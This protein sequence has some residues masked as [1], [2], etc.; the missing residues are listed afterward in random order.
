MHCIHYII[1]HFYSIGRGTD[2]L[3]VL[4]VHPDAQLDSDCLVLPLEGPDCDH[5]VSDLNTRIGEG[6]W[7][8]RERE[9]RKVEEERENGKRRKEGRKER[10]REGNSG[11][12]EER[13]GDWNKMK[14]E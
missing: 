4:S 6:D 9:G 14:I 5:Q 13:N 3:S 8:G 12:E 1:C 10:K 7:R 2:G 11:E